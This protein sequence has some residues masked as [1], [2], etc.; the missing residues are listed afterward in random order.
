MKGEPVARRSIRSKASRDKRASQLKTHKMFRDARNVAS[1]LIGFKVVNDSLV[2]PPIRS[3]T[4][5]QRVN[6]RFH[7]D[8]YNKLNQKMPIR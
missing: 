6:D 8:K 4:P 3:R 7:W 2:K 5:E 1:N